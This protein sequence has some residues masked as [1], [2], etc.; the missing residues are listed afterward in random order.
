ML[1][2]IEIDTKEDLHNVKHIIRLLSA[3]SS[4][5]SGK[6]SFKFNDDLFSETSSQTSVPETSPS[7]FNM[8]DSPSSPTSPSDSSPSS[9]YGGIFNEPKKDEDK[10]DFL[11]SLQVY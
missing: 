3:I 11:D 7:L 6:D 10:K 9:P 4:G 8:F 5:V 2:R 1:M